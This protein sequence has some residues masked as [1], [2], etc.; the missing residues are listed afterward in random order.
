MRFD[1]RRGLG[2]I[3]WALRLAERIATRGA[4]AVVTVHEPYRRALE[5]RGVPTAKITVVLNSLDERLVPAVRDVREPNAFRVIYHGTI[6]PHYGI[7]LLVEAAARVAP[8]IPDLSVEIYGDG[9]ALSDVRSLVDRL[10]LTDRVYLSGQFLPQREVL[11]RAASAA[12]GVITN[13]PIERNANA[14]PTKLFE[15][16]FLEVPIVTA[17][18]PAIREHFSRDEVRFFRAGDV[19]DLA[20]ALREVAAA[21]EVAQARASAARRR[22]EQYRWTASARRYVELLESTARIG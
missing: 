12:V 16:A 10:G 21:P 2:A 13:L 19:D 14:V 11:E 1:G 17:D 22:Y 4:D 20:E 8:D 18:L 15:Y 7:E 6:T 3:V 5:A 9:D